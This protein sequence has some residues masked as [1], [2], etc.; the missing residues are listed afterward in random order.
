MDCHLADTNWSLLGFFKEPEYVEFF[1][2]L[3]K[4]Q[5]YCLWANWNSANGG[6][7][8][9]YDDTYSFMEDNQYNW[10][11][12]CTAT[13]TIADGNTLYYD[14]KPLENG[15]MTVGLYTDYRCT[16]DYTGGKY[17][18]KDLLS[19]N[20]GLVTTYED[21]WN[22]ALGVYKICQPCRS[23]NLYADGRRKERSLEDD[24]STGD[25]NGYFTCSD[26]A[27]YTGKPI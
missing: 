2:Q 4:H 20:S 23:Y 8:S 5:G 15:N 24:W 11:S 6:S 25:N 12:D 27:G 3:F 13:G 7:N 10:P 18:A 17:T 22:A 14:L 19:G 16:H 21:D 26:D 1:E 9:G